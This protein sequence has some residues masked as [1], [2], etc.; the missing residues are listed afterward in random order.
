MAERGKALFKSVCLGKCKSRDL[1]ARLNLSS[2]APEMNRLWEASVREI[3]SGVV[4]E[5][6]ALLVWERERLRLTN[7]VEGAD[8]RAAV[9]RHLSHASVCERFDGHGV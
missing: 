7:I 6:G 1:P 5:Y 3:A 8:D 4:R 2:L 9:C